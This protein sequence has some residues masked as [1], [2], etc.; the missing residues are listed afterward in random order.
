MSPDAQRTPL[1]LPASSQINNGDASIA[2]LILVPTRELAVQ[3]TK[4][5]EKFSAFCAKD[6]Q[7]VG[8]TDKLPTAVQRSLLLSNSPDV[9]VSTP[10]TAWHNIE[11]SALALDKLTH[12]V[13]DEAD[14]VLS[15]G[16]SDDLEKVA[17]AL[18]KGVQ[19]VMTSAT[20]TDEIDTLKGL[21]L[22]DSVMLDLEEPD[23]EGSGATQYV[24]KYAKSFP[25]VWLQ[26]YDRNPAADT[27]P[28]ADAGR[29]RNSYLP[30]SCLSSS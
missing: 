2:A 27:R 15:Y 14:L 4:E 8:L 26:S 7:V 3:V 25:A 19:T 12:L 30:T 9:I 16:Y 6:I 29:T 1:I 17:Q 22:R 5:V 23:A 18:P 10:S 20:L 11:S 21:F 28:L 13:L 24:V